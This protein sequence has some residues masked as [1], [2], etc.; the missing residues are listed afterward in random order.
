MS[1]DFTLDMSSPALYFADD[2]YAAGDL[3]WDPTVG[4]PRTYY[5]ESGTDVL[6]PV[7]DM[8]SDG[9]TIEFVTSGGLYLSTERLVVDKSLV[10]RARA[11]IAEKPVLKYIGTS[12]SMD[13][14]RVEGS[15]KLVF[16]GLD[17]DGDG[18]THGAAGIAKYIFRIDTGDSTTTVD[19]RV[20][21]CM[22]HDV[23]DKLVKPYAYSGIDTM[24]FHGWFCIPD[25]H[26][27]Q[28]FT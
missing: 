12:T 13:M 21:D 11:N 27:I 23:S 17:L 18:T 9:D 16:K 28:K 7:I 8:A 26:L 1:A 14:F 10:F 24:M 6:S 22:L 5:V 20:Y 25:H 15:P 3:R 2:G 19:L 4:F